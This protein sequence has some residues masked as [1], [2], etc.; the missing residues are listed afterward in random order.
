[1]CVYVQCQ[2]YLPNSDDYASLRERMATIVSRLLVQHLSFFSRQQVTKHIVH[3]L[4]AES[5][6]KSELVCIAMS[7]AVRLC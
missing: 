5:A 2:V 6:L 3:V 7:T 1:V 4:T